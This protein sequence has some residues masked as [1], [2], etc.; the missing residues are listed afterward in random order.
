[1]RTHLLCILDPAERELKRSG[2]IRFEGLEGGV[3]TLPAMES[4]GSAYEQA[5]NAHLA[6]LK[7][8]AASLHADCIMHDTSQN[9][10]PALLALHMALGG[11]R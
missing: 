9:P 2:R 7:Q 5:M 3:L 10:L 8:S 11:G 4:L 6:A 1:M